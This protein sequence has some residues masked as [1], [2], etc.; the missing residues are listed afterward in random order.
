MLSQQEA[1]LREIVAMLYQQTG[2][3]PSPTPPITLQATEQCW[4]PTE[5][6]EDN[7]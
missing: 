2:I 3:L 6:E 7:M 4:E 5:S 1:R